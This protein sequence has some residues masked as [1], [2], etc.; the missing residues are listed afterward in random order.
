M[1][2]KT[3]QMAVVPQ[4][5]SSAPQ[6]AGLLLAASFRCLLRGELLKEVQRVHQK[7]EQRKEKKKKGKALDEGK[8]YT[9]VLS[10]FLLEMK[11]AL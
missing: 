3:Q 8:G 2:Q 6:T 1:L 4:Y 9:C 7:A 11:Q 5:G 10:V